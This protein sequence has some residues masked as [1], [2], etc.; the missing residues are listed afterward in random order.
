MLLFYTQVI[1]RLPEQHTLK[2]YHIRFIYFLLSNLN[3]VKDPLKVLII[4]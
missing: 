3:A 4:I 1:P 2:M